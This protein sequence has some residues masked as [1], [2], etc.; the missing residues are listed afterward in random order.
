MH[1]AGRMAFG[2]I[3]GRE[4]VIVAFNVGAFLDAE[5]EVGKDRRDLVEN[6]AE[7][8]NAAFGQRRIAHRQGDIE[9]FAGEARFQQGFMQFRLARRERFREPVF[10]TVEPRAHE[11]ALVGAHAAQRLH[12][13]AHPALLAEGGDAHFFQH[14][15]GHRIRDSRDEFRFEFVQISHWPPLACPYARISPDCGFRHRKCDTGDR[16]HLARAQP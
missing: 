4:I 11:L 8:M 12:Q 5:A 2:E 7:R 10:Q 1:L 6:L 13:L 15:F 3:Q 16:P 9:P 14:L